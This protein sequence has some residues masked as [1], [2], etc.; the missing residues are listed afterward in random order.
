MNKITTLKN[1]LQIS[2]FSNDA[3]PK[4]NFDEQFSPGKHILKNI[5]DYSKSV[6]IQKSER[7]EH[8]EVILN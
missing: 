3:A 4:I 1:S 7:I 6:Y 2:E 5:M 8:V